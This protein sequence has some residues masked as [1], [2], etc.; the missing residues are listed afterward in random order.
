LELPG[1]LIEYSILVMNFLRTEKDEI[2]IS[3]FR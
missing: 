1:H 3:L 2:L